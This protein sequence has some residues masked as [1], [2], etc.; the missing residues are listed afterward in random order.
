MRIRTLCGMLAILTISS[1]AQAQHGSFPSQAIFKPTNP[2][3]FGQVDF[4]GRF[5][6]IDGDDARYQRYRD[7]R[8]GGFFDL[9]GLHWEKGTTVVD[10]SARNVGW[11]DQRFQF[12]VERP[13]ALRLRILFD[14]TPMFI[15]RDTR[16]PYDPLPADSGAGNAS[17]TLSDVLQAQIQASPT[18][19]FR[20]LIEGAAGQRYF[21]SR[22]RRDTVGFDLR[23]TAGDVDTTVN[24]MN[25]GKE[26][27]IPFGAYLQIPIEV[28]LPIDSR[29]ND[30]RTSVE[31]AS[32]KGMVRAGWDSSWYDNS[33][34]VLVWDNPQRSVDAS[35]ASSQGR[36]ATW[37]SNN[38]FSVN[39][40]GA[41]RMPSRT[42][43]N[44]L[45][46]FGRWNQ[47]TTLL[48]F[49][50]NSV[51]AGLVPLP[52]PTAEAKM[53]T[54]SVLLNFVSKPSPYFDVSARY[55][56][57]DFDN[58][59]PHFELARAAGLPDRVTA[60][61][62]AG[63]WSNPAIGKTGPEPIGYRRNYVDL[64]SGISGVPNTTF[65]VGYSRYDADTHYRVFEKVAE[66][67]IRAGADVVGN[68]Y[69]S[70]RSI[71]EHSQRRGDH[72][73][74]IALRIAAEQPGMRHFDLASR[75]RNRFSAVASLMPMPT[76]GINA[77]IA[78]TKDAYLNDNTPEIDSFGLED[79]TSKTYTIGLDLSP[80]DA[81]GG[82]ISFSIDDYDGVQ[83]SRNAS[84]G[85][86]EQDST[87]NWRLNE[88]NKSWSAI[89]TLDLLRA[90]R[91]TE[92][93]FSYN[94]SDWKG[95]Y[96]FQLPANSTLTAPLPLP[97]LISTETRA[98]TDVRYFITRRVAIGATYWYD[99][100]DVEDFALSPDV[101][102]G[103]A[104]PAVEAGQSATVNALL[105]N[106]FYRPFTAHSAWVRLT[107]LW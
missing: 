70:F 45:V 37:P 47:D 27:N 64:D 85:V 9:S 12:A 72:F 71:F 99:S 56:F 106:Y 40:G 61:G 1:T 54:A 34:S 15:S 102:S 67:T 81:V 13:G 77:S 32:D 73:D 44:G 35:T 29:T 83:R 26:G 21:D 87:R 101:V 90:I 84:P 62:S 92:V 82:G 88:G 25:T 36:M 55:R 50:I 100:Y 38:M 91:N 107:Y 89:G 41:Y 6:S 22:L 59:T 51:N 78:W 104:Q 94:Y 17:L 16:T 24:Y 18:T 80:T 28:P 42:T 75:D 69:V 66:N 76:A 43:L 49:T 3:I 30:V 31:W 86:Q 52:R 39:V 79:V 10:A 7:L 105:M 57:Y 19:N 20:P 53:N 58:Q 95:T 23:Y 11:K 97:E 8:N 4:G 14:Q 96:G 65:R 98:T 63:V 74:L 103:I 60:D 93:R 48:P 68:Q 5:S 46:A 2:N 33:A